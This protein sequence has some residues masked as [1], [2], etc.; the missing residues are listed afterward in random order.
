MT[1]RDLVSLTS[2]VV[3]YNPKS[4]KAALNLIHFFDLDTTT[5]ANSTQHNPTQPK[6]QISQQHVP[7]MDSSLVPDDNCSSRCILCY[8]RELK[9]RSIHYLTSFCI[10]HVPGISYWCVLFLPLRRFFGWCDRDV[11]RRVSFPWQESR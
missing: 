6:P 4:T 8:V 11:N 7:E 1:V 3:V 10:V 2:S 9:I 5:V